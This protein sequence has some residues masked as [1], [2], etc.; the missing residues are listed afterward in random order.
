[1]RTHTLH[2][3]TVELLLLL[4]DLL[5]LCCQFTPLR[6]KLMLLPLL[7]RLSAQSDLSAATNITS[8]TCITC[9]RLII[10]SGQNSQKISIH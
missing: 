2:T 6:L 10:C 1:M 5:L 3:H 8:S 4:Q 9:F 7:P